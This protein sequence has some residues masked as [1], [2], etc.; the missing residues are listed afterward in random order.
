MIVEDYRSNYDVASRAT[1]MLDPAACRTRTTGQLTSAKASTPF[2]FVSEK[3]LIACV[4]NLRM[5]NCLCCRRHTTGFRP[6]QQ[7]KLG[8]KISVDE[9]ALLCMCVGTKLWMHFS[10]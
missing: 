10:C 1:I 5:G 2:L 9:L 3:N 6:A 4:R 7:S 8:T